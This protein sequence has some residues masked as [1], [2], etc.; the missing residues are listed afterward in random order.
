MKKKNDLIKYL[1]LSILIIFLF[2]TGINI[3]SYVLK[4][5]LKEQVTKTLSEVSEQ[6]KMVVESQISEQRNL[7][8]QLGVILETKDK[9]ISD[10]VIEIV[11]NINNVGDYK[12]IGII[13]Q[14]KTFYISSDNVVT[15]EEKNYFD[16]LENKGSLI[17]LDKD[18][19]NNQDSIF[20]SEPVTSR[21]GEKG[22]LFFSYDIYHLVSKLSI[23]SFNGEGYTY[24][25]DSK[26]NKILNSNNKNSFTNFTNIF[27][28]MLQVDKINQS[29]VNELKKGI[30]NKEKGVLTF[31]NKADKYMYYNPLNINDWYIL[32]I[33]PGTTINNTYNEI[34]TITLYLSIFTINILVALLIFISITNYVKNKKLYNLT[35][36]DSVTKG[37]SINKFREEVL[38]RRESHKKKA[39][40]ALDINNFKLVNNL[41]GH[42]QSNK[43]LKMIFDVINKECSTH[44]FVTRKIADHFFIYYEY[45]NEDKL[46]NFIEKIYNDICT[47]RILNSDYVLVPSMG[48][49]TFTKI[50][51]SIEEIENK[52]LVAWKNIKNDN[53]TY[54]NFFDNNVLNTMVDNK[55][56]LD[57][58]I[59]GV[60]EDRLEIHYQPKYN[61]ISKKVVGAEALLRFKDSDGT[62]ISPAKF[63]PI[64]EESGFIT[65]LDDYVFKKLCSDIAYMKQNNIEVVPISVNLSRKK[66]EEGHFATDYIKIMHTN[67]VQINEL[68]L[69]MTEGVILADDKA[70]KRSVKELKKHGFNILVDDF[71]TGYSSIS[72]L[73]DMDI[74]EVKIDK[75]F[76]NDNS[77]KGREIIK[78]V[79]NLASALH[80]KTTAEGVETE[81]Q[82]TMLKKLKCDT[83]QGF[84]FS[85]VI[86]LKEFMEI[87]ENK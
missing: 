62:M 14:E 65:V 31:F 28:A 87:L 52:V 37:Y 40:I 76:I 67:N 8:Q 21:T 80:V 57:K 68:E 55:K 17:I 2:I 20:I 70:I 43:I 19:I 29:S 34:M 16:E 11:K 66:L 71:G 54:Y 61:A 47:L 73:K 60:L 15:I 38:K 86:T 25:V 45:G 75:S 18:T 72:T 33:V 6:N 7:V 82:Y 49:Y 41:F 36:I 58:L 26:G 63:I 30:S 56:I 23:P 50:D 1:V 22:C 64:A 51:E 48:V 24:I 10:E 9:L 69:E 46:I 12:N 3:Y 83:I 59:N 84:Y 27:D 39:I 32:T 74:D 35:Y 44:G 81:E 79:L 85:K 78:Y 13:T 5:R 53:Y 42:E 77:E 4:S